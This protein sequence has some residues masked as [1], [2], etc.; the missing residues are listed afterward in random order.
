MFVSVTV[1]NPTRTAT[2]AVKSTITSPEENILNKT[3]F[4]FSSE[5]HGIA[6]KYF[7]H[8][9]RHLQAHL[10]CVYHSFMYIL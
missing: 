10:M 8:K 5:A 2:N 6:N 9:Y 3:L 7:Q 1:V 4:I